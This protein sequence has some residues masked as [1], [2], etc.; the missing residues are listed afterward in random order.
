MC[1]CLT[2]SISFCL[3]HATEIVGITPARGVN[4]TLITDFPTLSESN[5]SNQS[6]FATH[7]H[8]SGTVLI[9]KLLSRNVGCIA[10]EIDFLVPAKEGVIA[11]IP[12]PLNQFK[13]VVAIQWQRFARFRS[14][15]EAHIHSS[16]HIGERGCR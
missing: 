3:S 10:N 4:D 2:T 14:A 9:S 15:L 13:T 11:N 12:K 1:I 16:R 5:A 8:E 7:M 6:E